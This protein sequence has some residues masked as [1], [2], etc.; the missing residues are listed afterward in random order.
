MALSPPSVANVPHECMHAHACVQCVCTVQYA[1]RPGRDTVVLSVARATLL[2]VC[3]WYAHARCNYCT[4]ICISASG[5][6]GTIRGIL[7]QLTVSTLP[8]YCNIQEP[9]SGELIIIHLSLFSP[10]FLGVLSLGWLWL[11]FSSRHTLRFVLVGRGRFSCVVKIAATRTS[12]R[13]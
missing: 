6:L 8:W 7:P 13:C 11:G 4:V 12:E 3:A 10:R 2:Q 5:P 9:F 1:A